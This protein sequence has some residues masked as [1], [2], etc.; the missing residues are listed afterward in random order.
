MATNEFDYMD[1]ILTNEQVGQD[2]NVLRLDPGANVRTTDQRYVSDAYNYY[3]GGGTGVPPTTEAGSTVQGPGTAA[4]GTVGEGSGTGLPIGVMPPL[5]AE[6]EQ[7]LSRKEKR[8]LGR[9]CKEC[10]DVA[11]VCGI[12][13][14]G[15]QECHMFRYT[16]NSTEDLLVVAK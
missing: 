6:F 13:Q 16:T 5:N 15:Y 4:Q 1:R 8:K 12:L 10:L 7:N 2:P 11:R 3:L 9:A 14:Y